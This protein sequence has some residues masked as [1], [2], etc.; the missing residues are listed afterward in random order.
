MNSLNNSFW[1]R[2]Y[3]DG[4]G[5][6]SSNRVHMGVIAWPI[7][8]FI[9]ALAL[10]TMIQRSVPVVPTST[11]AFFSV[12]SGIFGI[13]RGIQTYQENKVQT[14]ISTTPPVAS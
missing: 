11:V 7:G 9:L 3:C 13:I 12:V 14:S 8:F 10:V 2:S 5:N 4:K 1:K 6:P